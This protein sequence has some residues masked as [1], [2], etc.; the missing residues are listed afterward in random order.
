MLCWLLPTVLTGI[1]VAYQAARPEPWRDEIAS[2]SAARRSTAEIWAMGQHI[3]GVTVPYYL[4]AHWSMALFG[5]SVLALRIPSLIAVTA[6][7]AVTALLARRLWGPRAALVAGLLV[8][9][10]PVMS[11]YA[12]EA[13][14]YAFAALF[15]VLS[16]LLLTRA[17]DRSRWASWVA[18]ALSIVLLGLAHQIAL[19]LLI[20]HLVAVVA[21]GWRRL[22]WWVP[23]V[24][25]AVAAVVPFARL[26]LGQRGAQLD[27]LT[28]ARPVDLA[29]I[30][31]TIFISGVIGGAV[32]AFATIALRNREW[33]GVLLFLTALLPVLA[34]YAIDQ[35]ITPMFV[36]RYLIFVVPLL[37][38]LAGRGL[39]LL[40]LPIGV[41]AVLVLAAVG[42]P[43]QDEI[44]RT[45]SAFDYRAAAR[46]IQAGQIPGDAIVYAPRDGW[47]FTD[48]AMDYYAVGPFPRDVLK[49]SDELRNASL[50]ATECADPAACFATVD[51]VWTL[52]ADN[53]ETG[54]RAG[55][56]DQLSFP[57]QA[58][59][60]SSFVPL[61]QSR[62]DGFTI[63]LFVRRR[64]QP[65]REART[66]ADRHWGP[67]TAQSTCCV[68]SFVD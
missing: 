8:A 6:T 5:D 68:D 66:P 57:V 34:L 16:T 26:G 29:T 3:D 61:Q 9:A 14:G 15:A 44:R 23:A 17:L 38:A 19:L 65:V 18:Y 49:Q 39:S 7:T 50:W 51:R 10:M 35:L 45:H 22:V 58:L 27:W 41:T 31:G 28:A 1:V 36:G 37:C 21:S 46:L 56:T 24:L 52:S 53:L 12:Q 32:C 62:V 64:A 59:L 67:G 25:L 48:I 2:W 33:W 55:L 43:L 30:A 42:L 40:G 4:L 54:R 47:Q 20:G 11:R 13:R 63:G 60:T